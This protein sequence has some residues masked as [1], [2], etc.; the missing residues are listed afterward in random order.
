M[1]TMEASAPTKQANAGVGAALFSSLQVRDVVFPNRIAVS[2]MCQYS[3]VDGFPS[4]WHLVHLGSRAV[5]GAGIVMVE[6][7]G[8]EARGRISPGDLGIWKNEHI[9][10]FA[11][12]AG[13]VKANGSVPAIQLAHA[14][15][16]GST[17]APW[18]GGKPLPLSAD[19]W[20]TVAP[21]PIPFDS[22]FPAPL[23]LTAA[24]IQNIVQAFADA[25]RRAL[26]AGFEVI[27]IHGAHG[28]LINEFLSPLSNRRSDGYGGSFRNRTRFLRE[29]IAAV[30]SVWPERLPVFL[31]ISATDWTEGGWTIE[32]S[33]ALAR[34][35]R[36]LG[37]DLID[38]SSGGNAPRATIPV[39]PS[40]QVP[41]ADRI[42]KEGEILTGA[43]GLITDPEQADS[44]VRDGSADLVLLAR[45]MLRDPYWPI[46][47]ARA[48]GAA[49]PVP[50]QYGRAFPKMPVKEWK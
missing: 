24:E 41:F 31:R 23:E 11:R 14:G 17:D 46:H 40:Y 45:E 10:A 34:L 21:S 16:K 5:G 43:V 9:E 15:R 30:R 26:A 50:V 35:V 8:V 37:I 7:T 32:D 47:A 2:P 13:F 1:D 18:K 36:P 25:A 44:I 6:A 38:V 39:V 19:G 42:R 49:V 3:A 29:V 48:L 28:Y 33:I 12:I 22:N 20:Q 4:D 27:E